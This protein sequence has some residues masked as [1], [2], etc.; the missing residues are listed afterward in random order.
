[1]GSNA[2]YNSQGAGAVAMG[3]NAG[4]FYQGTDAIAIG[5]NAGVMN[6]AANSII[7]NA[8]GFPLDN[9]APGFFVKPIRDN[10][11][12][13]FLSYQLVYDPTSGEITY[14]PASSPTSEVASASSIFNNI[15]SNS[16]LTGS[17]TMTSDR[18]LKTDI[19]TLPTTLDIIKKMNPVSYKKKDSIASVNYNHEEMGFIAQEIQKV[20]PMLVVEGADKDKTLSV[21]YISLI[22]VLTKAIQEQQTQIEEKAKVTDE[23]KKQ[24]DRQQ[25]EINELRELIKSIKK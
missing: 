10:L 21:N 23:L 7:L 5:T 12:N 9:Y 3:S 2:G 16:I 19:K 22:P 8:S 11:G 14:S 6:Q 17:L 15:S 18:R 20:L 4:Y 24:L 1:M 25:K 13:S